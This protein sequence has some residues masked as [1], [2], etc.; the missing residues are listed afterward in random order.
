MANELVKEIEE[1][2]DCIES[3]TYQDNG[4]LVTSEMRL[5]VRQFLV[6]TLQRARIGGKEKEGDTKILRNSSGNVRAS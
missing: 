2:L 1:A 6:A 3:H 4:E 5:E